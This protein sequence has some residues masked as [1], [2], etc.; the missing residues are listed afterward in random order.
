VDPQFKNP[1]K[2]DFRLPEDSPLRNKGMRTG[3]PARGPSGA[4]KP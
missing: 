1:D 4:E 3:L 2:E